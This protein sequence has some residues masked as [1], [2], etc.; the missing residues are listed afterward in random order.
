MKVVLFEIYL[1][2]GVGVVAL[3]YASDY[4]S[5][6]DL[7]DLSTYI[8]QLISDKKAIQPKEETSQ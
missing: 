7:E 8:N 4:L 5:I 6:E 1:K 3:R 2:K